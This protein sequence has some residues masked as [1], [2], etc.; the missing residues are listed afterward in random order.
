MA[1]HIPVIAHT[2]TPAGFDRSGTVLVG[3]FG[4]AVFRALFIDVKSELALHFVDDRTELITTA[5]SR[6]PIAVLLPIH[7]ATGTTCAPLAVRL[8][9]EAPDVRVIT[10]WHPDRDRGELVEAIRAGSE[11]FAARS[12]A[13]VAGCIAGLRGAGSLSASDVEALR[14]LL[15]DVQPQWLVDILLAAVRWAHRGLSVGDFSQV[16][17]YSRRTL[18]RHSLKAGWPAPEELIEWGRLLRASLIE[19]REQSSLVALAHASGFTGP[20]ALRRTADRLLGEKTALPVTLTPLGV[21]AA[22]RRRLGQ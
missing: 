6:R 20:Q 21:S 12:S 7:D 10:L 9:T 11:P 22:L 14:S 15:A 3:H 1:H 8:C 4:D 16:V 17:G 18:G 2:V 13:D 19:W 5:I